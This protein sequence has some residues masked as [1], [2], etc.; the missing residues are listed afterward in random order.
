MSC[1]FVIS[2]SMPKGANPKRKRGPKTQAAIFT[3]FHGKRLIGFV[4]AK[5]RDI[6][7][8]DLRAPWLYQLSIYSL[9]SPSRMSIILY[10]SMDDSAR[11]EKIEIRPPLHEVLGTPASVVTGNLSRRTGVGRSG[12]A[13]SAL[14]ELEA[15]GVAQ[16]FAES[17][18]RPFSD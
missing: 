11:D 3:V 9:A 5:C 15:M 7:T 2:L 12:E 1:R 8:R 4:D 16:N 6:W 14:S 18:I 10:A 13:R 17:L